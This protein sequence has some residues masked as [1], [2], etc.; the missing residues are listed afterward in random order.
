MGT[1]SSSRRLSSSRDAREMSRNGNRSANPT[2]SPF[3]PYLGSTWRSVESGILTSWQGVP[4][5]SE[6]HAA[7]SGPAVTA[8]QLSFQM[9]TVL[10]VPP[11]SSSGIS[12]GVMP[13]ADSRR[14]PAATATVTRARP[15]QSRW[16]MKVPCRSTTNHRRS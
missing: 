1:G 3:T 4:R 8:S 15:G 7:A 12:I 5:T 10:P 11:A 14:P 6:N 16:V 13:S 2:R 9:I